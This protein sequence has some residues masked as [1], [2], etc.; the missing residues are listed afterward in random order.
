MKVVVQRVKSASVS[1][2]NE[3]VGEIEQ[4]LMLLVGF[5]KGDTK[6]AV[7]QMSDKILKMRIF[8]NDEEKM[9]Y[10]VMDIEGGILSVSQ[11]TLY[12]DTKKGNRPN[13]TDAESFD[14]SLDLYNYFNELL[15]GSNL[16]VQTGK[17]G[18]N[19]EVS[20]INDGP[21]TIIVEK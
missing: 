6:E 21:V 13:F 3:I 9:D 4:G 5:K 12:A 18:A 7:E 8:E 1:V 16:D 19:M 14:K 10:S 15:A 17:F 20:L 11:F 2:N